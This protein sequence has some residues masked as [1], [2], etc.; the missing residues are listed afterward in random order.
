MEE[1]CASVASKQSRGF[2]VVPEYREILKKRMGRGPKARRVGD[3]WADEISEETAEVV[4]A[5]PV[6]SRKAILEVPLRQRHPLVKYRPLSPM[7]ATSRGKCL[8]EDSADMMDESARMEQAGSCGH[9][10]D[11][12]AVTSRTVTS[13]SVESI[14]SQADAKKEVPA[15]SIIE[16]TAQFAGTAQAIGSSIEN[17]KI[18]QNEQSPSS[19]RPAELKL[20]GGTCDQRQESPSSPRT[21]LPR[22]RRLPSPASGENSSQEDCETA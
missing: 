7:G 20:T 21:T 8:H 11:P 10:S 22:S 1:A 2:T 12:L 15:T 19:H 17:E 16:A 14:S 6:A 18:V 9:C 3:A 13:N 4:A 5:S